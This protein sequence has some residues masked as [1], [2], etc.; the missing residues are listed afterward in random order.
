[1]A[2]DGDSRFDAVT[3][4]AVRLDN[5]LRRLEIRFADSAGAEHVVSL[6]V[7]AAMDLAGLM[8]DACTF[9]TQ[10]KQGNDRLDGA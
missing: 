9:M 3:V 7:A 4:V 2:G 10:L 8:S 5:R 6:P 1:M